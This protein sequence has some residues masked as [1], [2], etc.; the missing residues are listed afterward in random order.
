MAVLGGLLF[1]G[2]SLSAS[3]QRVEPNEPQ[4][5]EDDAG[6]PEF[7]GGEGQKKPLERAP[8]QNLPDTPQQRAK[9][10]QSLYAHLAT[11][12]S[13]EQAQSVVEAIERL[14]LHSGS[15]TVSVLMERSLKAV[16]DN[17]A[18]LALKL[19]DAVVELAPDYAEGWNRRAYVYYMQNDFER[20][21]GDLRRV[22]AL[23]PSHFK[24]LDGLGQI[25]REIGQKKGAL[26][27]YQ[28]LLEVHPYWSGARQ[29]I[30]ELKREVEG[31][32]I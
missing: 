2:G 16:G 6:L 23:E 29:A 4:N 26:K 22:L 25:L 31:Q 8:G 7:S 11:A 28:R 12:D 24:A 27:A 1:I 20:A 30:D 9:L 21:L 13:E 15:D 3:A 17:N 32:P 19:L 10:L 5:E 14:W 18:E